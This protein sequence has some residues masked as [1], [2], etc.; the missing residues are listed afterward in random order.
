[1]AQERSARA[2]SRGFLWFC[3]LAAIA[4]TAQE[5]SL[6]E[7]SCA[8]RARTIAAWALLL[9]ARARSRAARAPSLAAV[10]VSLGGDDA[11]SS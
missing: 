7:R 8:P 4:P 1:V 11:R 5:R 3:V 6:P 9:A 10:A 2:S